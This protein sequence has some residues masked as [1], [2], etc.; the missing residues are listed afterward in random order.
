MADPPRYE[1]M[2]CPS[3]DDGELRYE[4]DNHSMGYLPLAR[5][6]EMVEEYRDEQNYGEGDSV[7]CTLCGEVFS[8]DTVDGKVVL[9]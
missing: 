1:P 6:G 7:I 2:K 4:W 3:C 9:T 8:Y 5:D